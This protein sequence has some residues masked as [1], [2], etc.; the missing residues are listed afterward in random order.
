MGGGRRRG[1]GGQKENHKNKKRVGTNRW[2][3]YPKIKRLLPKNTA[4][5]VVLSENPT[6]KKH[7]RQTWMSLMALW[8]FGRL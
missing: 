5:T 7:E 6:W 3:E 2:L 1:G 8:R 4:F